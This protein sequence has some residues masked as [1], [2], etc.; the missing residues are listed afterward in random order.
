MFSHKRSRDNVRC[1][2]LDTFTTSA[3]EKEWMIHPFVITEKIVA[4]DMRMVYEFPT[5]SVLTH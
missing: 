3:S 2:T 5:F 1:S 4:P